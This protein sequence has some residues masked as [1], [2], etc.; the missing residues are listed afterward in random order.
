M[1]IHFAPSED[2][3]PVRHNIMNAGTR[4][5]QGCANDAVHEPISAILLNTIGVFHCGENASSYSRRLEDAR[6]KDGGPGI[7][8]HVF[9]EFH[10]PYM[11]LNPQ[12][13]LIRREKRRHGLDEPH[14]KSTL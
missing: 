1:S 7:L 12:S 11:S 9:R 14:V 2:S 10:S 13:L 5:L 8:F 6:H 3:E 4:D